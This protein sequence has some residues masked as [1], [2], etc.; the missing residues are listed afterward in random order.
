MQEDLETGL[1]W[2]NVCR[3]DP[4]CK[5]PFG[6]TGSK[7]FK[8]SAL[9]EHAK[10]VAHRDVVLLQ[11]RD[12]NSLETYALKK[13]A[14]VDLAIEKLFKCAYYIAKQDL[15]FRKLES[16]VKL[17]REC[18][19]EGL[20]HMYNDN[21]AC[22]SFV[23]NISKALEV[24]IYNSVRK[25]PWFGL[26]VDE[27]TNV[28]VTKNLI[29]YATFVERRKAKTAYV[30]LLEAEDGN[31]YTITE[32]ILNLLRKWDLDIKK[33]M[34]F[35]S[36]GAFVMVGMSNG[37]ATRLKSYNPFMSSIHCCAHRTN[38]CVQEASKYEEIKETC[39][40]LDALVNRVATHFSRSS[41][42][43]GE[44]AKMQDALECT[45]LHVLGIVRHDGLVA[46]VQ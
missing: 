34:G 4:H 23:I 24:E 8:T 42:R 17:L 5:S 13:Q 10:C 38:L 19:V 6:T 25:N 14:S 29:L 35:G 16:L 43:Q 27:S 37:V 12:K 36:D 9:E 45:N 31:A 28:S 39:K 40:M 22:A 18:G 21:K 3:K 44:L 46:M 11:E 15:A 7:N 1:L 26:M 33:M 2:L 32:C 30:G 20:P 41:M